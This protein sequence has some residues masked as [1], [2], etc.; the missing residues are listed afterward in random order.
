MITREEILKVAESQKI[1]ITDDELESFVN[2]VMKT[3]E[4]VDDIQ[5]VDTTGIDPTYYGNDLENVYREDVAYDSH[6][7]EA[8]LKNAPMADNNMIQ[9]PQIME[10]EEA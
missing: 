1:A 4:L 7:S 10:S 2:Q 8:L 6:K 3:I 9:V 5:T